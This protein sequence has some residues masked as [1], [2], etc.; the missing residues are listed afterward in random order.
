MI[1]ILGL[2]VSLSMKVDRVTAGLKAV[3]KNK[4]IIV[5]KAIITDW[6]IFSLLTMSHLFL[7]EFFTNHNGILYSHEEKLLGAFDDV[8]KNLYHITECKRLWNSMYDE[9]PM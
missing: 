4:R 9:I 2:S 3:V 5:G 6:A 1:K 8:D 7:N